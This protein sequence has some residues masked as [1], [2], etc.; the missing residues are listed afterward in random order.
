M[1]VAHHLGFLVCVWTTHTEYMG[2]FL[3]SLVGINAVVLK[4]CK[5][6]YFASLKIAISASFLGIFGD[7]TPK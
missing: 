3:Q 6:L 7:M 5:F 4:I 2:L 1:M